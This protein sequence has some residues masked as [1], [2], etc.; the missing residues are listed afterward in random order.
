MSESSIVYKVKFIFKTFSKIRPY[1]FNGI[2]AKNNSKRICFNRSHIVHK[3]AKNYLVFNTPEKY[4]FFVPI[5]VKDYKGLAFLF[6]VHSFFYKD[7]FSLCKVRLAFKSEIF[8]PYS[9]T[10]RT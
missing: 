7:S 10:V 8:R 1:F 9:S 4:F 5:I 3:K 6:R 2:K